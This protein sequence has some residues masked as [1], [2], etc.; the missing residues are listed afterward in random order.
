[1]SD[2]V[3]N[4]F[5]QG[6][7]LARAM[8]NPSLHRNYERNDF[9]YDF[10]IW[11]NEYEEAKREGLGS[12]S[13][14]L[15]LPNET[16]PTYKAIGFLLN[17]D[18]TEVKHISETDS[19]SSGNDKNGDFRANDSNIG[20]LSE[21]ADIIRSKREKVMN[22][23]NVNM[24]ENA[25]VGLFANKAIGQ[26]P[27]SRILL[28]QKYYELQTG[29][30][31]PIYIYD[32][33]KGIL[34][35]YDI[36]LEQ[37]YDIVKKLFDDKVLRSTS[38]FYETENGETKEVDYLK[39]IKKDMEAGDLLLQ[40]GIN[41]TEEI[42]KTSTINEQ[43][44]SI[45]QVIKEKEEQI[46]GKNEY[47]FNDLMGL[48]SLIE[49]GKSNKEII[50][51]RL[52]Y[53]N[54]NEYKTKRKPTNK[55]KNDSGVETPVVIFH[56]GFIPKD[57]GIGIDAKVGADE[58]VIDNVSDLYDEIINYVRNN[59]EEIKQKNGGIKISQF[60]EIIRGYF[61][62]L[63]DEVVKKL[64]NSYINNL[65]KDTNYVE[66]HTEEEIE[67]KAKEYVRKNIGFFISNWQKCLRLNIFDGSFKDF[68]FNNSNVMKKYFEWTRE[69]EDP[70][71]TGAK[72]F[73]ISGIK[74]LNIAKCTEHAM[75][76]Q[77]ALSF[78]GYETYLVGGDLD[79][80]GKVEPHNYNVVRKNGKYYIIDS[81]NRIYNQKIKN[82][83]NKEPDELS[84]FGEMSMIGKNSKGEDI[85]ISY[86]SWKLQSQ[87]EKARTNLKTNDNNDGR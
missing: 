27:L 87:D 53:L 84:D 12:I 83:E 21:L 18:E 66:K 85:A 5:K 23:I 32:S 56:D 35:N 59:K 36:S 17:S 38:I 74:G 40:S 2:S 67:K 82:M 7:I 1:M 10:S 6:K 48:I 33:E 75:L 78:L 70:D 80:N 47:A 54:S 11:A 68:I 9:S 51:G 8:D 46:N 42:T 61:R 29:N 24:R 41:A 57:M 44:G 55:I 79:W 30:I 49:S 52:E 81:L 43:A 26:I 25:Y 65:K 31:L 13:S 62:N 86:S 20:S 71:L 58:Y 34:E 14:T 39:E 4:L 3:L 19:G 45:K 60:C 64:E 73:D 50:E 28:A 37:K 77:N 16:I 76:T 69:H 63:D 72:S 22:E 15:L